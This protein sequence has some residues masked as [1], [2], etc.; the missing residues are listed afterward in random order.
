MSVKN[1]FEYS[2]QGFS[3]QIVNASKNQEPE[4]LYYNLTIINPNSLNDNIYAPN[5]ASYPGNILAQ[6][7]IPILENPSEWFCSINRASVPLRNVPL[8]QFLVQTPIN[9]SGD[10]NTG[11][12]S[13]TFEYVN[14]DGS[15][16]ATGAQTFWIYV[17][18]NNYVIPYTSYP[19]KVQDFTNDYY[20]MYQ[21][22]QMCDIMNTAFA[23]ALD[24]LQAQPGTGAI[25]TATPPYINYDA[26]TQLL[27]IYSEET[28]YDQS[29][30][31]P[32]INVYCNK[33][34]EEFMS[35]FPK[36][37]NPLG[38][39]LP[40]GNDLLMVIKSYNGINVVDGTIATTQNYSNYGYWS[41]LKRIVIGTNMNVNSEIFFTN[42][43]Y[44]QV[45]NNSQLT[46][47]GN[48][49]VNQNQS[50]INVMYDFLPDL[51]QL[52]GELGAGSKIQI[53]NAPN[54]MYRPFTFNQYTPLY[55]FS[56][57]LYFVDR[58][59]NTF[60]LL[61]GVDET[62]SLKFQF[63]KKNLVKFG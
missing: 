23:S 52:S 48:N 42:Q 5:T 27:T 41:F 24:S 60:P 59:D 37:T 12:Y 19:A 21:V 25:S 11:I 46:P 61:L 16:I 63:I 29:T 54:N 22:Q 33:L 13:W 53:Y 15:V 57:Q 44:Q 7:N 4:I 6:N 56:V 8:I 45:L 35:G 18:R 9:S 49:F 31:N 55:E 28:F 47:N 14:A 34:S 17:P 62:A 50:Y 38:T 58:Y 20:F 10:A 32:R 26:T 43:T 30:V 1:A 51:S 3:N 39:G 36:I 2:R 40:N